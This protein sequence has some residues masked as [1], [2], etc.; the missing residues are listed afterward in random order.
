[1]NVLTDKERLD[2]LSVATVDGL[3]LFYDRES[4]TTEIVAYGTAP[5]GGEYSS[6]DGLR[7]AIDAAMEREQHVEVTPN[8]GYETTKYGP[9]N[10]T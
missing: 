7:A 5:I 6:P 2:W 9:P 3:W 10:G 4:A 1:M 8:F